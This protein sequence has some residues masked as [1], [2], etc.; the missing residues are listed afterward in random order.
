M[1]P[2]IIKSVML[3]IFL[4]SITI[5]STQNAAAVSISRVR[6]VSSSDQKKKEQKKTEEQKSNTTIKTPAKTT[7]DL[8]PVQRDQ[9]LCS[10]VS[11]INGTLLVSTSQKK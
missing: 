9:R 4:F 8:T 5:S 2:I 7:S 1:K 10:Q 11:S 3:L 6:S